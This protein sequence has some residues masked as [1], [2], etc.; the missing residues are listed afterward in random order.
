MDKRRINTEEC[1]DLKKKRERFVC[2]RW[3]ADE[4]VAELLM[5]PFEFQVGKM[6]L[7]CT[8]ESP[9]NYHVPSLVCRAD[10]KTHS[11]R[12]VWCQA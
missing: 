3:S 1:S 7:V 6:K 10:R 2:A 8:V 5:A 9:G 12:P 11:D 4:S